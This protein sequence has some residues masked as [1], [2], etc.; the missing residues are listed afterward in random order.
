MVKSPR[1]S[2]PFSQQ[3]L[4]QFI[5]PVTVTAITI[6]AYLFFEDMVFG[7]PASPWLAIVAFAGIVHIV[8]FDRV[9]RSSP[10]YRLYSAWI[11]PITSGLGVGILPYLRPNHT[12][13]LFQILSLLS[14]L[15]IVI[16]TGRTG[17][18]LNLATILIVSLGYFAPS[19]QHAPDILWHF[20]PFGVYVMLVEAVARI[21]DSA[22]HHIHRLETINRVSRQ[23]M[24]SLDTEQTISLLN[25]TIQNALEADTYYIGI[26]KD[27]EVHLDLFYDDGEYFNGT[28]VP[29]EGSLTGW[30]IKNQKELFLPDL[31]EAFHP[32]GA[33]NFIIG[34]EKSSLSWMG[35]PIGAANVT[36]VIALAS[37]KPNAFD[38]ADLE[39]LSNLA[40]QVSLALDNTIQH[41]KVE[42]QARLD[43]MTGVYNHAYFLQK[44]TEQAS[45]T[46]KSKGHLSLIMLDVDFFKKYNDTYGHLVGDQILNTLCM[47]IKQHIKRN[48]AVGRWGGE[49]FIISLAEATG[50]QAF[51]VAR[52]IGETL[53]NL[54]VED[55]EGNP[56]PVPTV[57]QGIAVFPSE[58]QDIYRLIDLADRRLY[59][60][61]ARGRNQVE[62]QQ[63]F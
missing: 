46:L 10:Q 58:A 9:M 19:L 49:E 11:N 38:T 18:Y 42:E 43:S 41:A 6:L 63:G 22:R 15:G 23:M 55:R 12:N 33:G 31:R 13:D 44:L 2:L 57:S 29:L 54:R 4:R 51:Q 20:A 37:Y 53:A 60:A 26:V 3:E 17:A 35:V 62:P 28:R 21:G 30:V 14:I 27:E 48:D 56:L 47:A 1:R 5:L 59:V 40:Q 50:E 61:K 24:M 36:G 52:R 7:S 8:L 32:E 45:E 34:R 25:A 39:L 16:S